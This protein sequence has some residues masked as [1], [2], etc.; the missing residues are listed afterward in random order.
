MRSEWGVTRSTIGLAVAVLTAAAGLAA[1]K[2]PP[3]TA[4][5]IKPDLIASSV[6][7]RQTSILPEGA[8]RVRVT[9]RVGLTAAGNVSTGPFKVKLEYQD[10]PLLSTRR[11]TKSLG[12]WTFLQQA[13]IAGMKYSMVSSRM[14]SE[15]RTFDDTVPPGVVRTY[16]ASV[17]SMDQVAEANESNNQA[18]D[19]FRAE[20]CAGV[21]LVVQRVQIRRTE[22]GT[23]GKVWVK[24]RCL[25]TCEGSVQWSANTDPGPRWISIA[26][27]VASRIGGE[28]V[29]ESSNWLNLK[30]GAVVA[31]PATAPPSEYV[32]WEDGEEPGDITWVIWVLRGPEPGCAET[33]TDN[34]S[35]R[36]VLRVGAD[37]A[38]AVCGH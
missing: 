36:V 1:D 2:A 38:S 31:D 18:T 5:K 6:N 15:T 8:Y 30:T 7:A 19:S 20:G 35:C 22:G 37:S 13:G 25:A 33:N 3:T 4:T 11:M 9:V 28:E 32:V 10:A 26:Q 21:D 23:F 17:D 29:V 24:N 27:T 34:N 14:P 12:T 16:R